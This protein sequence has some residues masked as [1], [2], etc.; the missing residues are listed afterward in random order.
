MF[1]LLETCSIDRQE[2][3]RTGHMF[4]AAAVARNLNSVA[5]AQLVPGGALQD[6]YG[7]GFLQGR[8]QNPLQGGTHDKQARSRPKLMDQVLELSAEPTKRAAVTLSL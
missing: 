6:G 5:S 7:V 8:V 4:E 3:L 1:S 2:K